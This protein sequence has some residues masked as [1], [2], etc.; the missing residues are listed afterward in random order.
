VLFFVP[1]C[2]VI[3]FAYCPHMPIGIYRF[4]STRL[5]LHISCTLCTILATFIADSL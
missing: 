1:V 2:W 5:T 4:V 3:G